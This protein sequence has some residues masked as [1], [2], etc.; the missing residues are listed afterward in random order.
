MGGQVQGERDRGG[1]MGQLNMQIEHLTE[2]GKGGRPY[3]LNG[4]WV[5]A[6]WPL[7]NSGDEPPTRG[8]RSMVLYVPIRWLKGQAGISGASLSE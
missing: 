3:V 1:A 6:K 4:Q 2:I 7:T 8:T 5:K